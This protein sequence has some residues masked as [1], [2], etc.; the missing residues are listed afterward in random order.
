ML[1]HGDVYDSTESVASRRHDIRPTQA[2]SRNPV[3]HPILAEIP[4]ETEKSNL[5]SEKFPAT[6]HEKT[7]CLPPLSPSAR[8]DP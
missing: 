1:S 3:L 6:S 4:Q 7:L 5:S 2:G 8:L